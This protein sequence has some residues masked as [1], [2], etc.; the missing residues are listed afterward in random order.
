MTLLNE[1]EKANDL[2]ASMH[3]MVVKT[4]LRNVLIYS[5]KL[6]MEELSAVSATEI[7]LGKKK[8]R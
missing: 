2:C 4:F 3:D 7:L 5:V 1:T 8:G 6:P